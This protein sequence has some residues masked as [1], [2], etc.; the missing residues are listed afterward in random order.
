V[1]LGLST[2]ELQA[3]RGAEEDET[4]QSRATYYKE[5]F[6]WDLEKDASEIENLRNSY[7][8]GW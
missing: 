8:E 3:S 4:K 7:L 1:G 6:F 5:K 2:S